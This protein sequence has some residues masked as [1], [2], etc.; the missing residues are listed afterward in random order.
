MDF[1]TWSETVE[2]DVSVEHVTNRH[3]F[4]WNDYTAPNGVVIKEKIRISHSETTT[5]YQFGF[6]EP[7]FNNLIAENGGTANEDIYE[8]DITLVV[9][10]FTEMEDAFNFAMK[11]KEWIEKNTYKFDK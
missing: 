10:K 7:S 4:Q 5:V 6:F 9:A 11:H 2:A 1:K 8:G 3:A